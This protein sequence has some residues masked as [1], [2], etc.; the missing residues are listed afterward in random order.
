MSR[1]KALFAALVLV[2]PAVDAGLGA[3][4]TGGAR[5]AGAP[6]TALDSLVQQAVSVSPQLRAAR[7]R[8]E[9]AEARVGPA[10]LRPDPMLMAG[11]ENLPV[12]AP[13]AGEGMTMKMV[14]IS[15]AIPAPG[16]LSAARRVAERELDAER[17]QGTADSLAVA[18]AVK[19]AWYDIAYVEQAL[20]IVHQTRDLLVTI[21]DA[22]EARLRVGT[23]GQVDVLR[24]R[25]EAARLGA[26][27]SALFEER[28]SAVARL[29]AALD[30]PGGA[31]LDAVV[32]PA[33]VTA[34]A[35]GAT[36]SAIGFVSS[37]LGSRTS[38]SPLAPLQAL[39]ELAMDR[40]PVLRAQQALV[41]AQQSR[42][43]LARLE[44]RPD[45]DV[46]VQ[47]GQRDRFSDVVSVV[48]S[49]PLP[50]QRGRR[51]DP[52]A[53]AARR[54]VSA[55]QAVRAQRRNEIGAEVARLHAQLERARTQLAL[56]VKAILPQSRAALESAISAWQAGRTDF[57]AVL[58][59]QAAVFN[60]EM[61][62]HQA[63]A[64]FAHTL[65]ELELVVGAEVL[66]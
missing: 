11:I 40:S 7:A 50:L 21:I 1:S 58:E 19:D 23:A 15:Q 12:S 66:R 63:L 4:E 22:A 2:A 18:R 6:R 28:R 29:N 45:L 46:S 34:A 16:K 17:A 24:A 33:G 39:Q 48:V 51:Q 54:E 35:V 52:L 27:A 36:P 30:R 9:A 31:P 43:E 65:A 61:M 38:D 59:S 26:E 64:D 14:G 42:A 62:Y 41:D 44:R 56:T 3:Q 13:G 53:E 60:T 25:V 55:L 47:Y 32:I 10:A 57:T 5:A 49:L 8:V 37:T 20:V